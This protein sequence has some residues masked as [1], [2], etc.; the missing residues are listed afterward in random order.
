MI[1]SYQSG[2]P[3]PGPILS[4]GGVVSGGGGG[5]MG[6]PSTTSGFT[7]MPPKPDLMTSGISGPFHSAPV[8]HPMI[9]PAPGHPVNVNAGIPNAAGAVN[10]NHAQP[11]AGGP[12]S[13]A[14]APNPTPA[15]TVTSGVN[16]PEKI[17]TSATENSSGVATVVTMAPEEWGRIESLTSLEL[18]FIELKTPADVETFHL[19]FKAISFLEAVFHAAVE[20]IRKKEATASS[21]SS[22]DPVSLSQEN[23][24][25]ASDDPSSIPP[26]TD[27]RLVQLIKL[28]RT[29]GSGNANGVF[30]TRILLTLG[31][32][33]LLVEDYHK[34]LSAYQL[35]YRLE[36]DDYWKDSSFL[37]GLAS[38]YFHFGAHS[39][40]VRLF[41]SILYLEP[42]FPR[43]R[44]IHFR[45]GILFK[46]LDD[47]QSSM[48]HFRL[49][50]PPP[51]ETAAAAAAAGSSSTGA[52]G[53]PQL[54]RRSTTF[55][56]MDVQFH[57]GHLLETQE[58]PKAA[59]EA[60]EGLL[61]ACGKL[62]GASGAASAP[63]TTPLPGVLETVKSNSLRHLGWLFQ[64]SDQLQPPS[65]MQ[66]SNNPMEPPPPLDPRTQR[67]AAAIDCLRQSIQTEE[68]S[69]QSW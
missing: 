20:E 1:D 40:S 30:D 44:E 59:K 13:L 33:N 60:Y 53:K 39:W 66:Q 12:S 69:G 14:G 58:R 35:Y 9:N 11:G 42:S 29:G 37:Y 43:L 3:G 19:I 31:H 32:L 65:N 4:G 47:F 64:T 10:V 17:T 25:S 45:L 68:T 38:C 7:G 15:R 24:S 67:T 49:S 23:A 48:K 52:D 46:F 22:A 18:G 56:D 57:I 55:T 27:S 34:S 50:I 54:P 63:A 2:G 28:G 21:S 51:A 41:Q 5:P 61:V 8:S 62:T 36:T 26:L 6:A 16:N